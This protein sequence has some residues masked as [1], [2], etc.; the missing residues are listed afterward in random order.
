M[1]TMLPWS[2]CWLWQFVSNLFEHPYL[3]L[4]VFELFPRVPL[5]HFVIHAQVFFVLGRKSQQFSILFERRSRRFLVLRIAFA[6]PFAGDVSCTPLQFLDE[7]RNLP[8]CESRSIHIVSDEIFPF[9]KGD[10]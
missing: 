1:R 4:F 10:L 5:Q 8:R 7:F 6:N 2:R 9:W 3:L